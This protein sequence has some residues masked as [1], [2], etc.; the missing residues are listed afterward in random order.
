MVK[1]MIIQTSTTE[2]TVPSDSSWIT[3]RASW[4]AWKGSEL[5][6][7]REIIIIYFFFQGWKRIT[8]PIC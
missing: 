2:L 5:Y 6:L 1:S 8:D 4:K 7:K 3:L